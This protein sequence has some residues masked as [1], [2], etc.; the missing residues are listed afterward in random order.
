MCIL[1]E[2]KQKTYLSTN[3][4]N[5]YHT[6]RSVSIT[7]SPRLSFCL[8]W[9]FFF[10]CLRLDWVGEK[11]HQP[12][13]TKPSAE[14]EGSGHGQPAKMRRASRAQCSKLHCEGSCLGRP[15]RA[16]TE[17]LAEC[18]S[19]NAWP[20]AG[21][22]TLLSFQSLA[23]FQLVG[24]EKWHLHKVERKSIVSTTHYTLHLLRRQ[25][26]ISY[27]KNYL[28]NLLCVAEKLQCVFKR[29]VS[30]LQEPLCLFHSPMTEL[31]V[32]ISKST[33]PLND[34]LE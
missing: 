7:E 17:V 4:K 12:P 27:K 11:K 8:S 16:P 2:S 20:T 15:P 21:G 26:F 32:F 10:S 22:A 19:G 14:N 1:C 5:D 30:T 29:A 24:N 23:S 28:Y 18:V 9:H 25:H 31:S 33:Q 13:P 6:L 34:D 3:Q